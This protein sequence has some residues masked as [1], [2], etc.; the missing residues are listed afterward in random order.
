L[1]NGLWRAAVRFNCCGRHRAA[2][3]TRPITDARKA[4]SM[5]N[6]L[7]PAPRPSRFDVRPLAAALGLGL[8]PLVGAAEPTVAHADGFCTG[9][10]SV[11]CQFIFKAAAQTRTVPPGVTT[12]S[13]VVKGGQG[14]AVG[15]G[16]NGVPDTPGGGGSLVEATIPVT[17]GQVL[18]INVGDAGG[19]V[20]DGYNGGG[21]GGPGA[22][23]GGGASGVR[24]G[25]FTVQEALIVAGGGGGAGA[26][27]GITAAA[28][29]QRGG[30]GGSGG[31]PV[32]TSGAGGGVP[33]AVASTGSGTAGTGGS[34]TTGGTGGRQGG[35]AGS[36]GQGGSGG[37]SGEHSGGGGGGAG[38][39]GVV[40]A[41]PATMVA[42]A[43]AAT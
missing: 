16:I 14:G 31:G 7:R 9:T 1:S 37:A 35:G 20:E 23:G 2:R 25:S 4:L 10:S 34:Q 22:G 12:A 28:N 38:Y 43:A 17:P 8:A 42:A 33:S 36:R 5:L 18:Q 30:A 41:A 40:A 11:T 3:T 24:A 15:S 39:Y 19:T 27:I 13:F 26:G 6:Q 32:A 29:G 21:R